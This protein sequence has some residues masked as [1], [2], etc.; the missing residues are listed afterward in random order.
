MQALLEAEGIE[1][2]C[3]QVVDFDRLFWDPLKEV[4]PTF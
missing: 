3:D 1:V 2:N 4:G